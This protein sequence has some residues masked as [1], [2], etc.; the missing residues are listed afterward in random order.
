M[1][2]TRKRAQRLIRAGHASCA[3]LTTDDAVTYRIV[4][5]HDLQ[6]TD[7]YVAESQDIAAEINNEEA[8]ITCP[9]CKQDYPA[10]L[11]HCQC[12]Y[13]TDDDFFN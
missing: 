3:G 10:K 4:N 2:I 13:Q 12:E 6:R 8:W 7:H 9:D 1:I 11:K 5:R